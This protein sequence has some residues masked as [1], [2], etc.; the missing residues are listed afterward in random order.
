MGS[1]DGREVLI[2]RIPP[3]P[4]ATPPPN[5][6]SVVHISNRDYPHADKPGSRSAVDLKLKSSAS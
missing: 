6:K 3:R 1:N 2:D 5:E 4:G